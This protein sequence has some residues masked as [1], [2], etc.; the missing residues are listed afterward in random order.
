M[1]VYV[2]MIRYGILENII[3]VYM[4]FNALCL[5]FERL[6]SLFRRIVVASSLL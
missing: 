2:G 6:V 1:E 3:E 4:F 5:F